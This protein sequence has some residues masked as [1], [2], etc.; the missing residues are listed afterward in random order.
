MPTARNRVRL[1]N[2]D[3]CGSSFLSCTATG[4]EVASFEALFSSAAISFCVGCDQLQQWAS[5]EGEGREE[6][7]SRK[8]V[9][10]KA[11]DVIFSRRKWLP[12]DRDPPDDRA[13]TFAHV[14][15]D[16]QRGMHCGWRERETPRIMVA[17]GRRAKCREMQRG[18]EEERRRRERV[19]SRE[20]RAVCIQC[21]D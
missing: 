14:G 6:K 12:M 9:K 8:H 17:C 15:P 5:G 4:V 7:R 19:G 16:R 1:T 10:S 13:A 3:D 21:A 18:G 20:K 2:D 11:T